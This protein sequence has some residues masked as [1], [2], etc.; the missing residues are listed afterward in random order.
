MV[1]G[2]S[3]QTD[4]EAGDTLVAALVAG[5]ELAGSE[6]TG[7]NDRSTYAH[8]LRWCAAQGI[9]PA[10]ATSAHLLTYLHIHRVALGWTWQN[11]RVR[12]HRVDRARRLTASAGLVDDDV[13]AYVR[14]V[15]RADPDRR[16]KQPV[17]ALGLEEYIAMVTSR[18]LPSAPSVRLTA[19]LH[20]GRRKLDLAALTDRVL[21]PISMSDQVIRAG[22][23]EFDAETDDEGHRALAALLELSTPGRSAN[24]GRQQLSNLERAWADCCNRAGLPGLDWEA[25]GSIDEDTFAWLC[26]HADR[27]SLVDRRDRAY[28]AAGWG[29]ARRN[30]CLRHVRVNNR[31]PENAGDRFSFPRSKTGP[32]DHFLQHLTGHPPWCPACLVADWAAVLE[33]F[34]HRG[35]L[36]PRIANGRIRPGPLR[37][38][39][40]SRRLQ[41]MAEAAEIDTEERRITTRVMRISPATLAAEMGMD[42][43]EIARSLTLHADA[44]SAVPYIRTRDARIL[45]FLL[46]TP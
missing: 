7:S 19:A 46:P 25:L 43:F 38:S 28:F 21:V 3:E 22:T 30:D 45:Q 1:T 10:L 35:Y 34:G 17:D 4:S 8:F 20:L 26:V 29:M 16:E 33:R 18:R 5:E 39:T 12:A 24:F 41:L 23:L 42:T 14:S 31:Q 6:T 27:N 44:N 2:A 36:F 37:A 13:R 11:C 9:D 15:K 40:M 32:F